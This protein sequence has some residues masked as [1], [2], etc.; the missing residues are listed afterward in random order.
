MAERE[1][2]KAQLAAE[3]EVARKS[4]HFAMSGVRDGANVPRRV[5]RGLSQNTFLWLGGALALGLF[6][7][8]RPRR[9]KKV[10]VMPKNHKGPSTEKVAS[11]GLMAAGLK[12]ALDVARP[13]LMRIASEKLRPIVED[14]LRRQRRPA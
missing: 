12:L 8:L 5:K 9:P 4:M 13:T 1:E 3:L 7:A 6:I 10:Y 11:V 14:Y 2:R